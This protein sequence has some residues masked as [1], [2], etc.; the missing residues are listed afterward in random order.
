MTYNT[1]SKIEPWAWSPFIQDSSKK[2]K[3]GHSF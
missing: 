1:A 3:E 2:A